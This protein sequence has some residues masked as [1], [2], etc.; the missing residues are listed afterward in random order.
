MI[1]CELNVAAL[2]STLETLMETESDIRHKHNMLVFLYICLL[3]M[4]LSTFQ[5]AAHCDSCNDTWDPPCCHALPSPST[6]VVKWADGS[7]GSSEATIF[8]VVS[9]PRTIFT[10]IINHHTDWT[11]VK[12]NREVQQTDWQRERTRED[13]WYR[14]TFL[15]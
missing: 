1:Y 6:H 8:C 15:D 11:D 13:D 3:L 14:Q 2:R 5:H 4:T 10:S 7:Q 9:V 12:D